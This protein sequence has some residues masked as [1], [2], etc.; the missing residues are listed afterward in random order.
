MVK[1]THLYHM[2]LILR[3]RWYWKRD[4]AKCN[5]REQWSGPVTSGHKRDFALMDFTA[6]AVSCLRPMQDMPHTISPFVVTEALWV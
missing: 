4:D 5:S 3:L 6:A 2:P 1:C